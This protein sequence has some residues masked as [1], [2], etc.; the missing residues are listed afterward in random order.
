MVHEDSVRRVRDAVGVGKVYG[1]YGPYKSQLGN[2]PIWMWVVEHPPELAE[3]IEK[4]RPH[5]T[6]WAADRLA[7]PQIGE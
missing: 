7:D 6:G 5:L 2:K 3:A 1:P 4:L